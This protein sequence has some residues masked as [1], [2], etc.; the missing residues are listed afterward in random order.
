MKKTHPRQKC[1]KAG[2]DGSL[3]ESHPERAKDNA[4]LFFAVSSVLISHLP[5]T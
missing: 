3:E 1:N 5:P 4:H 2:E